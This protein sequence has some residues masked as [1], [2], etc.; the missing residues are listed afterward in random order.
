MY[1]CRILRDIFYFLVIEEMICKEKA[2]RADSSCI[3]SGPFRRDLGDVFEP[4][5]LESMLVPTNCHYDTFI[6]GKRY[7]SDERVAHE[8]LS[9]MSERQCFDGRISSE[10]GVLQNRR[11][12]ELLFFLLLGLRV[13]RAF[14]SPNTVNEYGC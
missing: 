1:L 2:R 3:T 9:D 10:T 4:K 5:Y 11:L 12:F 13:V 6:V 7:L 14:G 8:L